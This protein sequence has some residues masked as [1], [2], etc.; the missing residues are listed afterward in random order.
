MSDRIPRR[1]PLTGAQTGV[2]YGQRLDPQSPV[3]NVGQYVEIEGPLDPGL[4]TSALRRTVAECEALT[5][6][7]GEDADGEPYQETWPGPAGGPVVPVLDHVGQDDPYGTA[8]SLMHRDMATAIDPTRDLL[9]CFSLHR[10]APDRTLWY[11]RVHHL[12]LDAYGFSLVTRRTA[13]V[14]TALVEGREA[15]SAPFPALASVLEEEAA[16]RASERHAADRAYWRERLADLP[17]PAPLSGASHPAAAGF[18]RATVELEPGAT[19]ALQAVARSARGTW[20]DAVTAGFA[21]WLHRAGGSRDVVLALPAMARLGSAAL[22]VP[23]MV[24]NVLP[25]RVAVRPDLPYGRLVSDVAAGVRELRRHQYHRGEEVRRELGPGRPEGAGAFGPMLNIKAFDHGTDFAGAPATVH[26]VTAGPVDDLTLG[27]THDEA[28]GVLRLE[29]DAHPRAYDRAGVDALAAEFAGYLTACSRAGADVPVGRPD[30][31][32]PT[33]LATVTGA[34]NDTGRPVPTE[35]VVAAFEEAARRHP[36]VPAVIAGDTVLSHAELHA[37]ADRLARLLISRGVG[38]ETFVGLALPRTADFVVALLAVLKAG[39]GY[40]PLDLEYPPE[41]LRFMVEDARPVCVLTTLE[42]ADRAP[43]APDGTGPGPLV[44]DAPDTLAELAALAATTVTDADRTAALTGSHPAYVIHTSGSTGRPKGVVVPHAAL[45]HFLGMQREV[46][47]LRPADRLVAVTTVSFDIHVL[48]IHTPLLTGAT[49]VLADRDTVREPAALAALVDAHRPAVM[50]ATPSLWHALLEDGRPAALADTRVLVGGEA[51]PAALAER[52]ARTA[53]A[54]TNVYGP[55][56]ATVWATSAELDAD[57]R[58]VPGIGLPFWNTR[59]QVLDAALRPVPPGR[60]GELYLSGGQLARGYLGRPALTSQRFTADPFGPAGT[61]MYRT[62]DLVRRDAAGR[63][64]FVGRC[65]DQVKLRGHRIEPGEVEAA[66]AAAAGTG[67]AVVLVREDEPGRQTLVGY[68]TRSGDGAPDPAELRRAVAAALPVYMVPAAVVVLDAFPLTANGKV[69][70]KALPAP[71]AGPAAGG[72]GGGASAPRG[73][74]EE[75]VTGILAEVLGAPDLSPEDDFFAFGG[76]SLPASRAAARLRAALGT[77]CAIR[78]VFEARTARALADRLGSGPGSVGGAPVAG[79]AAVERPAVLPLSY[80]QQRLWF[81]HQL[82][83]PSTTYNIPFCARFEDRLDAA[84]LDA[85]LVDTVTRHEALRTVFE[86]HDG[87]P[88]QRVLPAAAAGVRLRTVDVADAAG[89]SAAVTDALGHAFDLTTAAPVRVTLVRSAAGGDALVVLLHHIASDEWSM[90]PFL[91]DLTRAYAARSAG[92]APE[93]AALPLQYADY[94]LWQRAF[95]GDPG[96]PSSAAGAQAAHWRRVLAGAPPEQALPADRGR[97]ATAAEAAAGALVYRPVPDALAGAVRALARE[98]GTSVFMVVH[99]AVAALLHRLGA[100]S[101]LVLGTPVAGR[102]DAALD[103]LVGFFVNTLALRTDLSGD[104]AFTEL[105]ER[106]RAADLTALDHADLPFDAVVEAVAP[107]RSPVRHPL[108]QTMVSHSTVTQDLRTLFGLPARVDRIDPGAAKFDLDITFSDP[109]HGTGLE[110]E[111]FYATAL[112]DARTAEAFTDRLLRVLAQA[113]ADPSRP[114]SAWELLDE[115]E[116]AALERW[117]AT[118]RPVDPRPVTAVFAASVGAAPGATAVVA[119]DERLSFA[120]LDERAG[121]LAALLAEAGAGPD[122]VVALAVPRCAD[123]VVALLAVLKAGA[124][125]LPLDLD[126]PAERI[127]FMLEDSAPV[128]AVTTRAAAGRLP[129]VPALVLDDARTVARLAAARPSAQVPVH[130]EHAA[131]VIYTSGSTGVPKGVVLR[132]AGLTRLFR[133]HERELYGPVAERL[134]RRVRALHTA[135]FSFDSSWE[136]LL[137]LIAGH[138]LHVLDEFGRRDAEAVVAYVREHRIDALDVT[139]SYGRQLVDAGLLSG[140]RRPPLFLLGGEAVPPG[141]WA[142]LRRVPGVESVNYYGPTEFTVDALVARVGDCPSPVVGR[143]LDN[144]RAYVLD[145]GLRPVPPGVPGELYLAGEQNARG[146]LGRS[147]LTSQRF[148]ADPLGAPGTRMYRTGDLARWRSDG[149]LEFL[150]RTDDQVKVRGFRVEPGEVEAALAALDGVS[151]A[152]VLV[153]EDLPGS[154]GTPELVGYAVCASAGPEELRRRLAERLPEHLVPA[155]VVVLAELP[156]NVNGKLDR[157]ALPAPLLRAAGDSRAPRGAAEER[158]A[159]VFAELLGLA[160]VG[161]EDDFFRLGGHSLLATRL[162]ARLRSSGTACSVRDVF[163]SRTVAGLARR[164]AGR[165]GPDRPEPVAADRPERLPMALA[166]A[167]LWF[168]DRLEGPSATYNVPLA[169]DLDGPVDAAAL[170]AAVADVV[171]RHEALRTVFGEDAQGPYQRVLEPEAVRVPFSVEPVEPDLAGEAL[172]AAVGYVFDLERELPVRVTLMSQSASRHVL[173]VLFHHI[174]S[175][176]WST[177]PFLADLAQAYAARSAGRAPRFAPLPVQYA[178]YALWQR[179]LLGDGADPASVAALQTEHWRRTLAGI[180]TE[181]ALPVDRA[182][183]AVPSHAGRTVTVGLPEHLVAGL[184]ALAAGA[185]TTPFAVVSAAVA[186][187]LH[188]LGAG[189]DVPLGFPASGRS[190]QVLEPLVGFFVNTLVL[191][192]D[193]SGDPAFTELLARTSRAVTGALDHGDLPFDAV[194]EAVAPERSLSRHPVFQT[195]VAYEGGSAPSTDLFGPAVTAVER[196]VGAG[197]A[198]FDLEVLFRRRPVGMTCGIRYAV[199]LFDESTV[200][201]LAGRLVQLLDAAA[202][203]PSVRLSAIP[204][205]HEAERERVL[206]GFNDTAVALDGPTT[207]ADLVES[208]AQDTH[209]PALVFEGAETSRPAFEAAVNRLARLLISRGVG[210]E[211]TV[212]VALPRSPRLLIALHAVIRAGAAYLPLDLTLPADRLA[213]M[214]RTAGAVCVLTD[215]A[216]AA[217][218]PAAGAATVL[219]L[220]DARTTAELAE[221]ATGPV[222]DA[223]RTAPLLPRHPAYLIFTSGST[224]RPKGVLVEHEAIINRLQWMQHTYALTPGDRVLHKTPTGFDVSVWELF[225]PLAQGVPLVIARPDGHKEPDYLADLINE[226]AVTVCHFVPSML[227]AY[228][229][230]HHAEDTPALRLVVCSGE[231]LT[232]DLVDRFHA[233]NARHCELANLYGPTEAAVDVTAMTTGPGAPHPT[234]PI[235]TPVWNTRTYVLDQHLNPVPPGTPGELYLAGT[236]LARGYHTRPHLTAERFTADPHGP[237]GTRMYRT[238]DLVRH[239][240]DGTLHYLGRTDHQIKLRGLRIE[241]TEIE[242][243]LTTHPHLTHTTVQLREDTPGVQHLV[244]YVVPTAGGT[245]PEPAELRAWAADRLPEYMVPSFFVPLAELPLSP[246]GKLDRA[247]LPAPSVPAATAARAPRD[248]REEIAAG[249]FA[250]VLG[251]QAVGPDDDFFALGGHSL[252]AARLAARLA[253]A[254]GG[255][256]AVRDVFALRS[257]ARL[258]AH[259]AGHGAG[260]GGGVPRPELG[261]APARRA[262]RPPLSHAQH[263]LWLLDA[264]RGP[265]TVYNVPLAVRLRGSVDPVVLRAAVADLADRHEVLRTVIAEHEGEPYQRVLP[266]GTPVVPVEVREVTADRVAAAAVA[267]GGHVFDLQ[268]EVPLRVTLLRTA[269]DDAVL[270]VLL[271]HIATDEASAGPLL[272][273]LAQAYAARS[274]G[275]APRFEPLPVQYADYALWQRELLG[276]VTDPA[277]VAAAQAAYWRGALAGLPAEV[278]LP[279]DRPRPAVPTYRGDVVAFEVPAETVDGLLRLARATG[280]TPFMVLHAAVA[281]LLH[282]LGAGEDVPLGSPVS[283]RSGAELDG[284]VGFFLNT[285]VLRTD[286]SGD[287]GFGDLVARVRDVALAAFAHADLPLEAVVE[288]V[289]PER[290]RARN[291]LFQTMVTYHSAP[292]EPAAELL[293]VPAQEFPVETGGAKVDLE[294]AFGTLRPGS[295]F[296][297]GIRYAADL[298]DAST[299]VTLAGRLVRLLGAVAADPSVRLSAL[300]VLDEAERERVLRGFN[301]TAVALDGPATLAD[302]VEAGA[303]DAHGPALVF[304]GTDTSRPDFEAAVNRLARLLILRGVGPETTV[305]VALPRSPRLLIALHAV[306]RAGAAYLPLDLTLPADRLAYMLDTGAP[307]LTLTDAVGWQLL[308]TGPDVPAVVLD[309]AAVARELDGLRGDPVVDAERTAP[310]LPRHPAYLIFTSGST[311]RPKGVLVEHEA[312]INRLQWMQHT[313]ALTPGD[314]VLHKT[315]TGFDVSVWELFWP[316]AQG[317]PLVIARPDGHKEPDYLNALMR[318]QA[319]TVCH[320]VPS[321][322]AAY[323]TDHPIESASALRLVVCSGEALTADHTERFHAHNARG[324][325]LANLYGPTEAAVDVTAHTADAAGGPGTVPIGT[326]VWNTRTY[327]LDQHLNPVP[328][329]TPGELYLAGTQLARGY[330]TRPHLTAERFTADPHGPTGTRMYRTG[331]LV[332]H[333][334]DGTLHYLGRTDHQIKLRG[335]RIEPTEIETTLTTHPHLTHTTVQ[336]REDTPGIRRL[337]AYVVPVEGRA[338]DVAELRALAAARLPEY[339]VPAVFVTLEELPLSA[340]GKLDRAALPA[341]PAPPAAVRAATAVLDAAAAS[342]AGAPVDVLRALIAEVLGLPAVG[343]DDDFFELGGDSIVSIRL[344]GLA[345]KAGLTISA[346]QVFQQPT[347]AALAS[348]AARRDTAPE[349][350]ARGA[351]GGPGPLPLPPVAQWLARRG[352]P[353]ASFAQARLVRLPVGADRE[354]LRAALQAVLDHHDGLRQTLTVSRPGVWSAEVRPVGAVGAATVLETVDAAGLDE[355]ELRELLAAE[356]GRVSGML[357]PES[358]AVLRA[359]HFDRGPLATGRLLLAA[360]HLVVDEVSWQILLPDLRAAYESVEAGR[361]PTLEPV[362]TSLRTWTTHL[363][364][365]AQHPRRTAELEHWLAASRAARPLLAHR[366]LDPRSDTVSTAGSLTVTASAGRTAPLLREVPAAFHGTVGDALLTALALAVG[367]L[368]ARRGLP[369]GDGFTVDLEGHGREQELLAGADLTRTV[370]WLT[371]IHPLRVTA[372]SYDPAGVLAGRDDPGAAL[373]EVKELLRQVPDGGIG[374]GLLRYANPATARLFDREDAPTP[375]VLWNYLGRQTGTAGSDWGPAAEGDALAARPDPLLPLSHPVEITTGIGDGPDGPELTATFTWAGDAVARDAVEEL[376]DGFLSAVDA[377]A[378][379]AAH[380]TTG[381]HTPSDLDLVDLDQDQIT[382]LEDMWRA[383]Q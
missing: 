235:G 4:F 120:E 3:Y 162:V 208:G 35:P 259:L 49:I 84:A 69:D 47:G 138:E 171:A 37:R 334:P 165:S 234:A 157:A 303:H 322:L 85:A 194:V 279:T 353:F 204:L 70:R 128:C 74:R 276:D 366:A 66:L 291:P 111:V 248:A 143:P 183:P 145:G 64:E 365:E 300:P 2:W 356:S 244:A 354:V 213:Y 34:G 272:A 135:S 201:A 377:L 293:G 56:E 188:R 16:Y 129:G 94:A 82:E 296:E 115:E 141:L 139:P 167:R 175:D 364:A 228:L 149:L 273:D 360:H 275:R 38:P 131:Y 206:R 192:A 18:L 125:Y 133:D 269:A 372:R 374:A 73:A 338:V 102:S 277:S 318:E 238:G 278:A 21:A 136:Q 161:A 336:L 40:L 83:G 132:H 355:P 266:A 350:A 299:V 33:A 25:L 146:Y 327:V 230:D 197:A 265:G 343:P 185:G 177:G 130:P 164:L 147:A 160:A 24:V 351:D 140:D 280:A 181:P 247:A 91:G 17:D 144:A 245:A 240:P 108:F 271:H 323:L 142:E 231:A 31:L 123:S 227:A 311:G 198:K 67:R 36:D 72:P 87:V 191:R 359:I 382:M 286:L 189:E 325:V 26:N 137:W 308:P 63:L 333:T 148:V 174:A 195:M 347:P 256:C 252:L 251:R 172:D 190:A 96:D 242:T 340:N 310:L 363:L 306:I 152:A 202:A 29:L 166:Q 112:F 281:A 53:R 39:G 205:M 156:V 51:L 289:G 8:L 32:D 154:P 46:L 314:R 176:E 100:G 57:H 122:T 14:Y 380:G 232:T 151:A 268:R 298:F 376:A 211:T 319:V 150:G 337:V 317:V 76:H 42:G 371:A 341:P 92:R 59:A 158:V 121:R 370:G 103:P 44:L 287:P 58:G 118:D 321:M 179:E 345:R 187:L 330:H 294:L 383:Q 250:D 246:N 215:G 307:V 10:V 352:G 339:M 362:A 61:R 54:V 163:E 93:F 239:T 316:L 199:D 283:G 331:D 90:G 233:H 264:V 342:P 80:A 48:E 224:G 348:V 373:K 214:T 254:L 203:D 12:A 379:W 368:A 304:E 258:A 292:Q 220:D 329:G 178:D 301:D 284:L 243:T 219:L 290:S 173:L 116:R 97:P 52:L 13:E 210:P 109:A 375:E 184:E 134:G 27:V 328:P 295:G 358:G 155:A 55:T 119:G 335:L 249:V 263:R 324:A 1:L 159:S 305:A 101:D 297:G 282:R 113:V 81:L 180:P 68:V 7:F 62:G 71:T 207:L 378:A 218:V 225:W 153:R 241:P 236:Q 60:T 168:L 313:Y 186:A 222:V 285:L 361:A 89:A 104:P 267:A 114:V 315:P 261:T 41:R 6:R 200:M 124:A 193:L 367:D 182:R 274:A 332:R 98:T 22:R 262:P 217:S 78:D 15:G 43:G 260:A 253:R 257:P 357:D 75:I 106:V 344:V 9:Y 349:R 20:A 346:R 326:P 95:L 5:A 86:E 288:A 229:T 309:S 11:Q 302:L 110:L 28:R 88:A 209:G 99:A 255:D 216:S 270:L 170:R 369:G 212:A 117:N 381:G 107:E 169:L 23:A 196:Q 127:A 105:L 77:D 79:P 226:Q 65:D 312:I 126:H 320:F 221:L 30:L 50:Q 237:T 19:A 45:A 223:E